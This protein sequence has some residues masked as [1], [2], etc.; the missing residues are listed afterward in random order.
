MKSNPVILATRDATAPLLRSNPAHLGPAVS[1]CPRLPAF[2]RCITA[3]D[4]LMK[5]S[6]RADD[7]TCYVVEVCAAEDGEI[8]CPI[9]G[10]PSMSSE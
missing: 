7:L 3:K 9:S 8:Y 6:R 2:G 10:E 4:E 5:L 1:D